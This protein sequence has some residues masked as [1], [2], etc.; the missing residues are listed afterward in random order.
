MSKRIPTF[1]TWK[2]GYGG[3]SVSVYLAGTSTL[4]SLYY[5]DALTQAAPNPITL[6]SKSGPDGVNYGKFPSPIYVGT[7]YSMTIDG[8]EDT[9]IERPGLSDLAGEDA[10]DALVTPTGSSTAKKLEDIVAQ[11]VNVANYGTFN[12]GAGGVAATNTSTLNLAIAALSS[13]GE[14]HVPAGTY[15]INS[16]NVPEGVVIKGYGREATVLE[17]VQGSASFIITGDRAGFKDITLDGASLTTNSVGVRAIGKNEIVFENVMIRR[18]EK[19]LELLG[20]GN[21]F[22]TDLSIENTEIGANFLG[23][24]NLGGG[25][26]GGEI[27]DIR[28]Y[29]GIV[30]VASDKGLYFSYEDARCLNYN[31]IGVDFINCLG[32]AVKVNGAQMVQMTGCSFVG[33][34]KNIEIADDTAVLT[35]TSVTDN[36]VVSFKVQDGRMNGGSV[37]VTG[38]AQDVIFDNVIIED[39]DFVVSTPI[40]NFVVLKNC[41]EDENVTIAGEA[42][43]LIRLNDSNNGASFGVTTTNTATKAWG[44]TLK[45]G[46]IAY[47]EAKV[48]GKGRNVAQRAIYH[49]GCGAFRPGSTLAYDAQTANFTVGTLLTGASS[50]AKARIQADSDSGT[51]GTLTLTDIEGEF[52]DNEIITD[53]NGTPGSA[54]ANGTLSH[55]N[56]SLDSG[57]NVNIRAVYE[58]NANWAAAFAANGPE[59]ELRVTGDTSQ[60]VEWSVHVDV[61]TT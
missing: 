59:V 16:V 8:I 32:T 21:C 35:G 42:T 17:S 33:N 61:V 49:I 5:D 37:T 52:I 43:K 57:G 48:I 39:V 4:A 31:L 10:S 23:D 34:T 36:K 20:G 25:G 24:Q 7:S 2:P 30:S 11:I 29:G 1:D 13:G 19:G 45:P 26:G 55:Q 18:F 44:L 58:T 6:S 3:A 60:V 15:K 27:A 54:T 22:W 12:A 51:T 41:L 40:S 14:V 9:G 56:V 47:L 38:T 50:G 53:S 46:Q 28:W